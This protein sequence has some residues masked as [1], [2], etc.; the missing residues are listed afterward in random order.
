MLPQAVKSEIR[1]NPC[2][3]PCRRRKIREFRAEIA[4]FQSHSEK[5]RS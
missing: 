3:F 4:E 1:V 5:I 2:S